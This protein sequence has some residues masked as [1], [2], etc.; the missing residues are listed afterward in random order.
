MV[1]LSLPV[2]EPAVIVLDYHYLLPTTDFKTGSEEVLELAVICCSEVV[3]ERHPIT[4]HYC[5]TM[6][7]DGP[8]LMCARGTG[9]AYPVLGLV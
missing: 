2:L 9:V 3:F 5:I 1:T 6:V 4:L 8:E 7:L